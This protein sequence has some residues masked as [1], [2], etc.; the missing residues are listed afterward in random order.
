MNLADETLKDALATLLPRDR[1]IL[2]MRSKGRTFDEIAAAFGFSKAQAFR[3]AQIAR[4][5][6]NARLK[7]QAGAARDSRTK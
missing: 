3:L 2:E 5:K 1:R 6:L 4:Q 7:R